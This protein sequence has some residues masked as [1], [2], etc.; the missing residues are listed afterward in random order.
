MARVSHAL[1]ARFGTKWAVRLAASLLL[2]S[3]SLIALVSSVRSFGPA[4][5]P[6][7][8]QP[9]PMQVEMAFMAAAAGPQA[10]MF[11]AATFSMRSKQPAQVDPH[12]VPALNAPLETTEPVIAVEIAGSRRAYP[13]RLL[14]RSPA[15]EV[16]NDTLA[17]VPIVVAWCSISKCAAVY[18]RNDDDEQRT[19]A[20]AGL[21]RGEMLL[22]CVESP[23]EWLQGT[24][25]SLAP[26][27]SALEAL[28]HQVVAA[29][30]WLGEDGGNK[31]VY[32]GDG[33]D[34]L[35]DLPPASQARSSSGPLGMPTMASPSAMPFGASADPAQMRQTYEQMI[36]RRQ[37]P[38]SDDD[39]QPSGHGVSD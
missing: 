10:A 6:F 19:F 26:T 20:T 27:D 1:F 35:K 18:A 8:E 38:G 36:G 31:S 11:P 17:G 4:L 2:V 15:T 13:I 29:G 12:V 14:E 5:W 3:I 16:V 34:R 23:G 24:G 28:P 9:Q 25:K 39:R 22:Y 30:E 37:A 33:A 32:V 21:M 7:Q